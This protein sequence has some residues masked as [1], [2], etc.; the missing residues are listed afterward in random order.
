[1]P[2]I[3]AL[4][5]G[6]VGPAPSL[7]PIPQTPATLALPHLHIPPQKP[8]KKDIEPLEFG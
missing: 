1:M 8:L 7:A 4:L 3:T 5:G 2:H 6:D